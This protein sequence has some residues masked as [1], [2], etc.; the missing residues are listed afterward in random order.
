MLIIFGQQSLID[1]K[2]NEEERGTEKA[3]IQ[4]RE[5]KQKKR[6]F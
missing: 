3:R 2:K 5:K 4:R 1:I 6:F